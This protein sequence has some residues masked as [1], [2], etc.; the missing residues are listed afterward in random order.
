MPPWRDLCTAPIPPGR[1]LQ[2]GSRVPGRQTP[3]PAPAAPH[4]PSRAPGDRRRRST[5]RVPRAEPGVTR[6][7]LRCAPAGFRAAPF[8][9][10]ATTIPRANSGSGCRAAT[11]AGC[12]AEGRGE[13]SDRGLRHRS[14]LALTTP[15]PRRPSPSHLPPARAVAVAAPAAAAKGMA[16]RQTLRCVD[17][18][19]QRRQRRRQRRLNSGSRPVGARQR[20]SS[21]R[22]RTWGVGRRL[23]GDPSHG[24]PGHASQGG[25]FAGV[26]AEIDAPTTCNSRGEAP[27]SRRLPRSRAAR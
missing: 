7:Q 13:L 1:T 10:R 3:A 9:G 2:A 14:S 6:A 18:R 27:S 11:A 19:R 16:R 22:T 4:A 5:L 12:G 21:E 23:L 26:E 17:G 20:A 15:P 8:G 25:A 24:S